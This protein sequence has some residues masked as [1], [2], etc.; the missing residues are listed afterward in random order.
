MAVSMSTCEPKGP[1][2]KLHQWHTKPIKI[3]NMQSINK[4]YLTS[5][6]HIYVKTD[7]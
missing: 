4:K 5:I 1:L 2:L 6:S 7:K 3:L